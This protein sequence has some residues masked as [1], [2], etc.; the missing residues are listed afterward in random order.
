MAFF[1]FLEDPENKVGHAGKS[2]GN[3]YT[4]HVYMVHT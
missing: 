1:Q 4:L 3:K 2:A